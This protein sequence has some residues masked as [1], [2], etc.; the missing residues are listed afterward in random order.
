[1]GLFAGK[2]LSIGLPQNDKRLLVIS[3]I[4]GCTVDGIS[5]A[6][7]CWIGRRTLRIEDYGKIAATFIDTKTEVAYRIIPRPSIRRYCEDHV[8]NVKNRWQA[9]LVGY[10]LLADDDLLYAQRVELTQSL[11]KLISK[12]SHKTKCSLCSEEINN[13]REVIH[14]GLPICKSCAGFSYYS[15]LSE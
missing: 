4:D 5:V 13:E 3:E 10:Q 11:E 7:N 12:K 15:V 9:H 1:M 2:L 8:S 6:T 14:R